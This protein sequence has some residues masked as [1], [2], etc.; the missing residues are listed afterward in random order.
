[1]VPL[2]PKG[3]RVMPY[4]S[5]SWPV[6][7]GSISEQQS[8]WRVKECRWGQLTTTMHL[9]DVQLALMQLNIRLIGSLPRET[10]VSWRVSYWQL[11]ICKIVH[12]FKVK[13]NLF[14]ARI[15]MRFVWW[16]M[17]SFWSLVSRGKNCCCNSFVLNYGCCSNSLKINHPFGFWLL[18]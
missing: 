18:F 16:H 2:S 17:G 12:T 13:S 1:M 15:F 7:L 8:H 11:W 9:S 4:S 6:P 10:S 5:L 14:W 3:T